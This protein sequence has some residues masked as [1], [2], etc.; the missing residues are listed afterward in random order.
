MVG[1]NPRPVTLNCKLDA[2]ISQAGPGIPAVAACAASRI[3]EPAKKVLSERNVR[4]LTVSGDKNAADR[5]L[6][7][8]AARLARGGC[9]RFLVASNDSQFAQLAEL[10]RLEIII[11]QSQRPAK[12][13]SSRAAEVFPLPC[14]RV[15]CAASLV[16]AP[17]PPPS[18]AQDQSAPGSL[19]APNL[20]RGEAWPFAA[21]SA[22]RTGSASLAVLGAG[23]LAS[24]FLFGAGAALGAA[25]ALRVLRHAELAPGRQP[26]P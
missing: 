21:G 5:A 11:W 7:A 15:P 23:M 24:G 8:E 12:K 25:A 26:P 17:G 9:G 20:G 1:S 16:T 13:Y 3:T 2:L 22:R 10:G 4:L 19:P 6:L 14:P 18:L